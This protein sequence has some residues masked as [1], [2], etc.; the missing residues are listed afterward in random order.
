MAEARQA[1]IDGTAE[2]TG[3]SI[4]SILSRVR[5]YKAEH[6]L[7]VG[8]LLP[9]LRIA[10]ATE[11]ELEQL[12]AAAVDLRSATRAQSLSFVIGQADKLTIEE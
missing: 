6:G 12:Q 2:A 1:W 4:L 8:S 7:S 11:A 5:R 10:A 9:H 3:Q